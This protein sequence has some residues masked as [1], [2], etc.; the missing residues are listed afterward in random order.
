MSFAKIFFDNLIIFILPLA[1]G[2]FG[3]LQTVDIENW[4]SVKGSQTG[5]Y[6]HAYLNIEI[7]GH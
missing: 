4:L 6:I 1:F 5:I 7:L 3:V 2:S